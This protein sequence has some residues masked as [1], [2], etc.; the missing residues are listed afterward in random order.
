MCDF[1]LGEGGGRGLSSNSLTCLAA[2]PLPATTQIS[3][4]LPREGFENSLF[5]KLHH[6]K[7]SIRCLIFKRPTSLIKVFS[8]SFEIQHSLFDIPNELL[9]SLK[10]PLHYLKFSIRCSIFQ[11][12]YL[13][14]FIPITSTSIT[15]ACLMPMVWP[16]MVLKYSFKYVFITAVETRLYDFSASASS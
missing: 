2:K 5:P 8:S 3:A 11:T 4:S 15:L 7:F 13:A 12:S 9:S 6:S 16:G 1:F 10:F 14:A